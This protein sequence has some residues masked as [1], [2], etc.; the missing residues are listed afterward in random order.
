MLCSDGF[1]WKKVTK[2]L[3]DW[4]G[5]EPL[6]R[7][8]QKYAI[9]LYY[10]QPLLRKVGLLKS[11]NTRFEIIVILQQPNTLSNLAKEYEMLPL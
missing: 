2:K 3:P 9:R 4:S 5:G 8:P 11:S 7:Q 6:F 10:H 1:P